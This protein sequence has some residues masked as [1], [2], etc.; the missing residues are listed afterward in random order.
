MCVGMWVSCWLFANSNQSWNSLRG[1]EFP[2]K[3][4]KL[5]GGTVFGLQ[6]PEDG[7]NQVAG[8]QANRDVRHVPHTKF[9][10][11]LLL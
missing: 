10:T 6:T 2:E 3:Q 9:V 8:L 4:F 1:G 11:V 5:P 7:A